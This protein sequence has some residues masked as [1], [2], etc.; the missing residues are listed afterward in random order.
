ML[1]LKHLENRA[2]SFR[3]KHNPPMFSG[4]VSKVD[5]E[6]IW[7]DASQ[8]VDTMLNDIAWAPLVAT[9]S[10]PVIFVPF[11]SLMFLIAAQE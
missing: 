9:I 5:T 1:D 3:L 4:I 8:V 7:I 10:H 6:G 11:S 2:V